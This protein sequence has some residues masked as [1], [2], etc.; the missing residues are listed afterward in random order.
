MTMRTTPSLRR[1]ALAGCLVAVAT[2][3]VAQ[4]AP[5]GG[6]KEIFIS[7]PRTFTPV[8]ARVFWRQSI[9]EPGSRFLRVHFT[10]VV[11]AS[12][13]DY[14]VV[15]KDFQDQV[16]FEYAKAEFGRRRDF[17]S[18]LV[19]G[20]TITVEV[21]ADAPPSGLAFKLREYVYQEHRPALLSITG[22]NDL[23]PVIKLGATSPLYRAGRSIAKLTFVTG[24]GPSS[25]T[26][27][28]VGDA[29]LMTNEHCVRTQDECDTAVAIFGYE[30]DDRGV[31]R[32]G[33]RVP[34]RKWI[35][36]VHG[37]DVSLLQ[38]DGAPAT[39]WGRLELAGREL[40]L[41][42][43]IVIIQH[44]GGQPKQVSQLDCRVSTPRAPGRE[45]DSDFGHMCDT[46]GGSSGS[47]VLDAAVKVVGLHHY[48]FT[49]DR[50]S[51]ENRAVRINLIVD[52]LR[53]VLP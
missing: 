6:K 17:W 35:K 38:L 45:E 25:C 16:R 37:L 27:F 46:I 10:D 34:C 22:R 26:G 44:P 36:S 53:G 31:V 41:D 8:A 14:R 48:G 24:E 11:D 47:P 5:E 4:P 52:A 7:S 49:T 32:P 40:A 1:L 29:L 18:G 51:K 39:R 43:S 19:D 28:L 42:E 20:D 21:R 3:A 50:W 15:V 12:P 9:T 30:E 23:A 2:P 13:A 33:E